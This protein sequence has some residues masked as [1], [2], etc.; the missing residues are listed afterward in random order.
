MSIRDD[1][2]LAKK[3][4]FKRSMPKKPKISASYDTWRNWEVKV[5]E[6]EKDVKARASDHKKKEAIINKS[7]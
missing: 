6:W 2:R 1:L 3:A 4:G 7:R 5:K